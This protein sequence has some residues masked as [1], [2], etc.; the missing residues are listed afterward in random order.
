MRVYSGWRMENDHIGQ[1]VL[2]E[3]VWPSIRRHVLIHDS[4]F[5]GCLGSVAF[6]PYGLPL[7]GYHTGQNS[8]LQFTRTG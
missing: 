2:A 5:T 7:P 8:F 3:A 6:P 1:D 4:I